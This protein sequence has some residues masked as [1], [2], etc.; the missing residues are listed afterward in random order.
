[1]QAHVLTRNR[2]ERV[3]SDSLTA[4]DMVGEME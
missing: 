2:I 3:L 4:E 1:M